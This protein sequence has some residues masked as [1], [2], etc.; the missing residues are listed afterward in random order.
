VVVDDELGCPFSSGNAPSAK[1][2]SYRPTQTG[3]RSDAPIVMSSGGAVSGGATWVSA[4]VFRRMPNTAV[5]VVFT[6]SSWLISAIQ[7]W[8]VRLVREV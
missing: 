2:I 4:Q 5:A 1:R 7:C 3:R 6:A 8:L